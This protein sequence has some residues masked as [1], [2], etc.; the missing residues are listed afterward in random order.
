MAAL[1]GLAPLLSRGATGLRGRHGACRLL[2]RKEINL[3]NLLPDQQRY[4]S[5]QAGET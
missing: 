1:C 2:A 3:L 5:T 4:V